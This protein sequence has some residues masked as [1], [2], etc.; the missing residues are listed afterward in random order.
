MSINELLKR[1]TMNASG[2]LWGRA[3]LTTE[4]ERERERIKIEKMRE[5]KKDTTT[6]D[7]SVYMSSSRE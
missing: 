1:K 6:S 4:R 3:Y 2:V 5:W 7:S